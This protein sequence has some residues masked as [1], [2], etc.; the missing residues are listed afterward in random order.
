MQRTGTGAV[1][2]V[3]L[4]QVVD[5]YVAQITDVNAIRS[6]SSMLAITDAS[7]NLLLRNAEP[8]QLGMAPRFLTGPGL[9]QFDLNILKRFKFRERYEFNIRADAINVANKVNF[10]NP[11]TNINSLTFGNIG[12]TS[13]DPRIVVLSARFTF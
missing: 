6:R 13:A 8:G 2:F 10:S 7:G 5:P 11:D 3:G 1:Y 12:G 9:I 4:K